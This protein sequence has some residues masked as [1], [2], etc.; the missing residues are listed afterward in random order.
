MEVQR[1]TTGSY[2]T[3]IEDDS[4]TEQLQHPE[5]PEYLPCP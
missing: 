2:R 3:H 1:M 4:A 5:R